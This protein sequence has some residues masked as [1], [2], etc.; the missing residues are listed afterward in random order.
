MAL[1][2]KDFIEIEFTGKIK[3]G[4][5]FDSNVK[6]NLEKLHAGHS[7][8]VETKPFV[9]CLGEGMFVKGVD[10]FLV[11][12]SVGEYLISL[13][14]DEAFG[15][16]DPKLIQMVPL[17]NF[18]DS[19]LN[20]IPGSIFNFDGR[21]AKVLTVTSGRVVVDFNNPLAGKS[22]EYDVKVLRKIENQDEKVKALNE[23]FL[24][25]QEFKF[26][27]NEK[28]V[29][30]EIPKELSNFA[31]L[32]KDK[33][34]EILGLDIEMKLTEPPKSEGATGKKPQ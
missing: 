1:G 2:K 13:S 23:F 10:N 6:E 28:K 17:K 11:G 8:A 22:V 21:I 18:K 3:G 12:R 4:E 27:V 34:K 7:H 9:F 14:P 29:S 32:F 15:K 5:I 20:P 19:N 26:S 31:E 33:Y 30:I 24:G 25:S 16:R